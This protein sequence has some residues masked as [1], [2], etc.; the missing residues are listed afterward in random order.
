MIAP[1][2]SDGVLELELYLVSIRE[3]ERA[4]GLGFFYWT[5]KLLGG[6]RLKP[7]GSGKTL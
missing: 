3:I 7:G 6:S 5:R 1:N 4:S 2:V